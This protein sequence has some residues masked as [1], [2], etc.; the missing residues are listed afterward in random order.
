MSCPNYHFAPICFLPSWYHFYT[1]S[2]SLV[3]MWHSGPARCCVAFSIYSGVWRLIWKIL[4]DVGAELI[5]VSWIK[6]H[7]SA[8]PVAMGLLIEWQRQ[9]SI[10]VDVEAKAGAGTHASVEVRVEHL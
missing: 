1:D 3:K 4:D 10:V 9:A 6:D 7:A 8:T 2:N 5:E